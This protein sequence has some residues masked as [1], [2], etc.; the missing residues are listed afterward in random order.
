MSYISQI[1]DGSTTQNLND[2]RISIGGWAGNPWPGIT[3]DIY[4]QTDGGQPPTIQKSGGWTYCV[5]PEGY[6]EC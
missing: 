3:G 4:L 6:A 5:Y 2:A 1:S